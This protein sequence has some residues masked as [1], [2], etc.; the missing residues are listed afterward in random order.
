MTNSSTYAGLRIG[1]PLLARVRALGAATPLPIQDVA[2]RRVFAGESLAIHSQTGTGKTLAFMLPLIAGLRRQAPR[3]VLVIVPSRELGLQAFE[4]A[5]FLQS[6][7]AAVLTGRSAH[8]L[9]HELLQH[10]APMLV[11]TDKQLAALRPALDEDGG[12]SLRAAVR[13]SLRTL[14][15]DE[16]DAVLE[17]QGR[18]YM[19]NRTRRDRS[20]AANP[21]V[22]ALRALVE[23]RPDA[24]YPRV[25]L[26][27]ASVRAL[28]DRAP[29]WRPSCPPALTPP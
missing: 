16:A 7:A 12:G 9:V 19:L 8:E 2:I 17:P 10:R 4:Y 29:A 6:G 18:G 21:A 22:R 24:T 23:R 13:A 11:A 15:I 25:Q 26:V 1:A 28:G 27:V 5:S 20:L 3:Q 14:V